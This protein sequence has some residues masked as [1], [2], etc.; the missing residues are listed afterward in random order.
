MFYILYYGGR[1][2]LDNLLAIVNCKIVSASHNAQVD[3]YVLSESSMF[4]S[5]RRSAYLF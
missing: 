4:I 2:A 3:A 5:K 1:L